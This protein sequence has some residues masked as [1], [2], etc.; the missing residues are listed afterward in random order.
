MEPDGA[1][2]TGVGSALRRRFRVLC[3]LALPPKATPG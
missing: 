3:S 2:D 1:A